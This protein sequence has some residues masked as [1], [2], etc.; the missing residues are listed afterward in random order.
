MQEC[1]E[2]QGKHP[3][4]FENAG[5][6][7]AHAREA[8]REGAREKLLTD[9]E[10]YLFARKL[11][12]GMVRATV[13]LVK[14]FFAFLDGHDLD[15]RAAT[16]RDI[17]AYKRELQEAGNYQTSTTHGY[18]YA[19]RNLY[20]WLERIGKV[21]INPTD[22]L[23]L[24]K[25]RD[26]IPRTVLTLT[27]IRKLLDAPDTSTPCGIRDK[28]MLEVFYST[29]IRLSELCDLTVYDVDVPGGYVRV[30]NG[31]GA[32]DRIVPMGRKATQYVREYLRHARGIFTQNRRDERA[33][34]VG[35]KGGR[36]HILIVERLVRDYARTAGIRKH[37]TPHALRHTC[38]THMLQGGASLPHIQKLLGHVHLTTT[39]V[40]TRVAA[41]E[42][43]ATHARTHPREI[44]PQSAAK[45]GTA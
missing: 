32:K 11:A 34:F 22:G 29:G 15:L 10:E 2:I 31:K 26:A 42:V 45:Q 4:P 18:L 37:V 35:Q 7:H 20:A 36:I 28:T 39:Q 17:E 6:H 8:T 21:L 5:E 13:R 23:S 38:A 19:V 9:F 40:Y 33:L 14:R 27:E 16:V 30:N 25:V 41:V 24:P 1:Q 12:P 44:G 3:R 43:K